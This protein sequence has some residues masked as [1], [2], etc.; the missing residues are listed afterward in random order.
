MDRFARIIKT[1]LRHEG[2]YV[3]DPKDPGGE[4]KY[5]ISKRSYP[6]LDI[7]NL[8]QEEAIEIYRRDWWERLRLDE[9]QDDAVATKALDTCV[10]VGARTGIKLLQRALATIGKPV[11]VDGILG[12]QTIKAVNEADSGLL[13]E[14]M[15]VEQKTH[16]RRLIDRNPKLAVFERGWMNRASS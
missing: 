14:A 1:V 4:T 13:L 3:N 16:Y 11:A 9:I 7:G 8:T 2:G 10:N 15:R 12:P 5:G 6:N